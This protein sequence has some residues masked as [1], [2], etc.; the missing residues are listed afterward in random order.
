MCLWVWF[1][2]TAAGQSFLEDRVWR[3]AWGLDEVSRSLFWVCLFACAAAGLAGAA[4]NDS[5]S[6]QSKP[7]RAVH[8]EAGIL[9]F[10]HVFYWYWSVFT[11]VLY[12]AH[13]A[14]GIALEGIRIRF[15]DVPTGHAGHIAR[16]K[17]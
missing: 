6:E 8:M 17:R 11:V 14:S 12:L 9:F 3:D 2:Q 10:A 4:A 1:F 7:F 16:R 13:I 15:S 5:L